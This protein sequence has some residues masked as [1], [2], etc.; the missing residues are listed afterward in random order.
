MTQDT[1]RTNIGQSVKSV[2]IF[3][4]RISRRF[5]CAKI[6]GQVVLCKALTASFSEDN[7]PCLKPSCLSVSLGGNKCCWYMNFIDYDVFIVSF[8]C[9]RVTRQWSTSGFHQGFF[10]FVSK[11]GICSSDWKHLR[12]SLRSLREEALTGLDHTIPWIFVGHQ[13]QSWDG[14]AKGWPC[15]GTLSPIVQAVSIKLA[16][17]WACRL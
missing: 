10:L 4:Q 14:R 9:R 5:F 16:D 3:C 11:S 15:Q 2:S 7:Q 13:S 12:G 1:S 8:Y 17:T 6:A